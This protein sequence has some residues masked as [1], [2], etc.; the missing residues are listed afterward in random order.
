MLYTYDVRKSIKNMKGKKFLLKTVICTLT[1]G[2]CIFGSGYD[3][4]VDKNI[5]PLK[6]NGLVV[7]KYEE[8]TGCFGA[9]VIKQHDSMDT[10]HNIF[11]CTVKD[12]KIWSYVLPND[13]IYKQAGSM[14]VTVVRNGNSVKFTFP[15]S[16]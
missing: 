6:I 14:K 2:S 11:F 1:L 4:Y 10:L 5:K 16:D 13:S 7:E 3:T 15:T 12:E 9:I 8:H